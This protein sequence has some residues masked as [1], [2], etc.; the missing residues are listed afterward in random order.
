MTRLC[1]MTLVL[2]PPSDRRMIGRQRDHVVADGGNLLDQF[3]A[4]RVV[5]A[6]N[7]VGV[8]GH[9]CQIRFRAGQGVYSR[10]LCL[11]FCVSSNL[12]CRHLP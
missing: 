11:P 1:S 4:G 10:A 8:V 9:G 7:G 12:A 6:V 2:R 5:P 3:L